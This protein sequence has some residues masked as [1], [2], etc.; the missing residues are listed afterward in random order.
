[1]P[2]YDYKCSKCGHL[3]EAFQKMSDVPLRDCPK[4]KASGTVKRMI[5][6]GAGFIFKG[7]GFYST[8]YKKSSHAQTA[9]PDCSDCGQSQ[10]PQAGKKKK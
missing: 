4:C 7:S 5:G 9:K 1:M 3:F 2:T 8:D 6:A 10:C